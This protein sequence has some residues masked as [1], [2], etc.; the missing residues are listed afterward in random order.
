LFCA[1]LLALIVGL[2]MT[3]VAKVVALRLGVV[4]KP[5]PRKVHKGLIPRMGGLG[6]YSGFMAGSLFYVLSHP[7]IV[8]GG[9][10]LG[11]LISATIVF[12]TGLV[13]DVK[14]IR[15]TT[16]LMGQLIAALVFVGFGGYVKFLSN[17]FGGDIIFLDYFGV[18][19]TVLWL[20]GISNAV[21]LI[22]GLDGLA[23]G[24]S[25]ISACTMAVVSL[26]HGYFMPAALLFVLAS[27]TLGFLRF[28]FSPASIFMGDSGSLTLG[29]VLGA[30]AIMGFAKGA[31]IVALVIPVLI[32]AIPIFDTFFAI[33]RRLIEHKPIMQPDKGHLHHRLLAMGLSHKQTVL[34][35]Y[36]I[37]M[38]MGCIAILTALLPVWAT[39]LLLCIALAILFCGAHHLGILRIGGTGTNE[40]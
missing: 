2:V 7:N 9:E 14:S 19:V 10:V 12:I 11:L 37:T 31:T 5:D 24:V 38:F 18:P 6:I 27:A 40:K 22:D 17:P 3:K 39:A 20:M 32:L 4:D 25:I 26:S 23:A 8:L 13:D 33:V 30:I 34:I 28:N 1:C 36:A 15:P 21:N 35:I 29:F 16:K